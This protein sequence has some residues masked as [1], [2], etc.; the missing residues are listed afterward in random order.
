MP[1]SIWSQARADTGPA[2]LG[3]ATFAR[4][5]DAG[6]DADRAFDPAHLFLPWPTRVCTS[7]WSWRTRRGAGKTSVA[8]VKV[9]RTPPRLF[10]IGSAGDRA[11]GRAGAALSRFHN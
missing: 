3:K 5:I 8:T 6:A 4:E 1:G 11:G 2:P 7:S 10:E 9:P